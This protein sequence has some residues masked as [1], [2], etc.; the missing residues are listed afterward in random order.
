MDT[1]FAVSLQARF[2]YYVDFRGFGN[3]PVTRIVGGPRLYGRTDY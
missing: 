1:Y 2:V 3:Y